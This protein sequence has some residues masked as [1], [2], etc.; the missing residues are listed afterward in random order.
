MVQ[1]AAHLDAGGGAANG[2]VPIIRAAARIDADVNHAVRPR[3]PTLQRLG[4]ASADDARGLRPGRRPG[5]AASIDLCI[6][7]QVV[8]DGTLSGWLQLHC[9]QA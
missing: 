7:L 2:E 6:R 3:L 9:S 8:Q 5:L 4:Q 1:E